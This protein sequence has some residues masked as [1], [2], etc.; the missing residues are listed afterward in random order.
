MNVLIGLFQ[1]N[2]PT[3]KVSK[4]RMVTCQP[5]SLRLGM[6]EKDKKLKCPG[7][8]ASYGERLWIWIT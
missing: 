2:S 1:W 5:S 3:A 6:S 8:R 7:V 4:Y